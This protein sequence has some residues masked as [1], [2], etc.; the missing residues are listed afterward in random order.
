MCTLKTFNQK[1]MLF[2]LNTLQAR[3]YI[4]IRFNN[5]IQM[6]ERVWAHDNEIYFP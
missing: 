2:F 6:T 5:K 3:V 4:T 1:L